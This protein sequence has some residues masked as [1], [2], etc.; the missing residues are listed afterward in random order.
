[1]NSEYKNQSFTARSAFLQG[2]LYVIK[3]NKI[4]SSI[5]R[6]THSNNQN[7]ITLE[8]ESDFNTWNTVFVKFIHKDEDIILSYL[9]LRSKNKFITKIIGFV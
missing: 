5:L 1:M 2:K 8:I 4:P 7:K 3:M 9:K 6:E